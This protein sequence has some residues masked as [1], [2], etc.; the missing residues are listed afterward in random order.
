VAA[1]AVAACGSGDGTARLPAEDA[2][3]AQATIVRPA[4]IPRILPV[5]PVAIEHTVADPAFEPLPGARAYFGT[6]SGGAYQIEVPDDWNGDLVYYAHGYRMNSPGLTVSAPPIRQHLIDRGYGWAASSFSDNGYEPGIAANDTL[7]LQAIVADAIGA[8][9]RSYLYGQSMGGHV[10][11]VLL[12]QHPGVFDGAMTECGAISGNEV[13]DYFLS[14]GLLA[15]YFSGVDLSQD[16]LDATRFAATIE[17]AV[18]PALGRIGSLTPKGEAFAD[19]IEN[20][21]GGPRPFFE[22]GFAIGY[23]INFGVLGGA[24]AAPGAA[25][26]AAQNATTAY[27]ID[28]GFGVTADQLNNEIVRVDGNPSY[29]RNPARYP[30]FAD[31][32]G[33]ISDPL[34]TLHNTGDLFVPISVEQVYRRRADAAGSSDYLVQRAIRRPGHCAFTQDELVRAFDDL[35]AWVG[36]AGRPAGDDLLGSLDDAGV[37]FTVPLEA[38][39]PALIQSGI[40][41]N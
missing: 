35:A 17:T 3:A 34:I 31:M 20:L 7:A 6:Y 23:P 24:V 21:T 19:V 29:R 2:A 10:V 12:E 5:T 40:A 37:A 32:T 33:R 28:E 39:D 15:G 9:T 38:T 11:A 4:A 14:W 27:V 1:L 8:P 13:L 25:N 36:G 18:L 30:E 41:P 26:A 16:T 22:E